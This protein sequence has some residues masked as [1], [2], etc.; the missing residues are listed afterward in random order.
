MDR[1]SEGIIAIIG[2]MG[3]GKSTVGALLASRLGMVFVDLDEAI[4]S[5]SRKS[6]NEIFAE[7]GERGF[8]EREHEALRLEL[9]EGS[10]VISCG[11]GVVLRED[12]ARMLRDKARVYLL[13]ISKEEAIERLAGGGE[14]PLLEGDDPGE[15]VRILMEERAERYL[16]AAH[17]VIEADESG[18]EE[19]A[20]E[21]AARWRK[22]R[23]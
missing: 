13:K 9:E 3:A 2:F 5:R 1:G 7:E 14:R 18:P 22:Y 17:E 4:V 20:E 19:I 6:I 8:R 21:I 10:K 23:S 12:N 15:T 16:E 11:G